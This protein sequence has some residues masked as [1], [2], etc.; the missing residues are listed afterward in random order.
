MVLLP[1]TPYFAYM[2]A[3]AGVHLADLH[4]GNSVATWK[5]ACSIQEV[6]NG[7]VSLWESPSHGPVIVA[8][9]WVYWYVFPETLTL[10]VSTLQ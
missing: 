3:R 9:I 2:D 10:L 8:H 6:F 1:G 5:S 4:A 7:G